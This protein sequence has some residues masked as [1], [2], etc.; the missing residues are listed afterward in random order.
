MSFSGPLVYE[1]YNKSIVAEYIFVFLV[2]FSIGYFLGSQKKKI[3]SFPIETLNKNFNIT[4]KIT[5]VCIVIFTILQTFSIISGLV[6]GKLNLS[7]FNLG[8]AYVSGYQYYERNSGNYSFDFILQTIS[9]LPYLTSIILG[10]YFFKFLSFKYKFLVIYAFFSVL[11]LQT[12]GAGKQKQIADIFIVL[13][14]LRVVSFEKSVSRIKFSHVFGIFCLI[15][16]CIITL[17]YI[18]TLRYDAIGV[19]QTNVL[20]KIHPLI[21]INF[22]HSTFRIF[23]ER[24]GLSL[25]F[26]SS[27]LSQ[28]YYGLS[29]AMQEGFL[30]THMVGNSYSLTVFL[31]RFFDLPTDYRSSYPYRAGEATGWGETKWYTAFS[32]FAGDFTFP[33]TLIIFGGIAFLYAK[34]WC[35]AMVYRNPIAVMLF[36]NLTI[37]IIFIPANNQLLHSPGSFLAISCLIYLWIFKGQNFNFPR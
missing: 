3:T 17:T 8:N 9:Y 24:I 28:G 16:I 34:V 5:K 10:I 27:Y 12:V 15:L 25:S 35:A 13:I 7:I 11:L 19:D 14:L 4:L 23:G 36:V 30:W 29:L 32:W 6:T 31:E 1:E 2:L 21:F 22:D 20:T 37:G 26:L 33:G 18:L